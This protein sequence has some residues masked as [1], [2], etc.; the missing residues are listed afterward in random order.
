[1]GRIWRQIALQR[2][3]TNLVG[4]RRIGA[5]LYSL[6]GILFVVV[7]DWIEF[8]TFTKFGRRCR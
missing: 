1:V 4:F 2:K 5:L 7:T 6:L 8:V 3:V